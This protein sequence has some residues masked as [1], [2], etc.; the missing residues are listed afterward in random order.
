MCRSFEKKTVHELQ[1]VA[2]HGILLCL[3]DSQVS[4]HDTTEPFAFKA[5]ISDIKPVTAFC[6][7]VT[8]VSIRY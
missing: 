7:H 6:S 4:A 1:V 5:A 2:R 3:S 8:K